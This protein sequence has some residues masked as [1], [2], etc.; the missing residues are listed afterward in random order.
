MGNKTFI[1]THTN[2]QYGGRMMSDK[3]KATSCKGDNSAKY[4]HD[5]SLSQDELMENRQRSKYSKYNK[6]TPDNNPFFESR[7]N[8]LSSKGN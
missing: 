1:C 6:A 5:Y 8:P 2:F 4:E 7:S 3:M